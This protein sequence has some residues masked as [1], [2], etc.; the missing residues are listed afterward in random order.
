MKAEALLAELDRL[1]KDVPKDA[2]DI[3]YLTLHHVF[4]FISYKM[5]EFRAYVAEEDKRGAFEEFKQAEGD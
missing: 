5:T 3:E 4:C 2:T 1:R